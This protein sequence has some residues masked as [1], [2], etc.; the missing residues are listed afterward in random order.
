MAAALVAV[1]RRWASVRLYRLRIGDHP[2]VTGCVGDTARRCNGLMPAA[3]VPF[4]LLV[5]RALSGGNTDE[6]R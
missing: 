2:R 6:D 5:A 4:G 3:E 1:R